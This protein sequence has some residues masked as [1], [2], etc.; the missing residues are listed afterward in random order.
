[1]KLS[2]IVTEDG[3][4]TRQS[5]AK[6]VEPSEMAKISSNIRARILKILKS[7][8]MYPAE[9]AKK[10]NMHEQKIYYHIRELERAGAIQVVEETKKRGTVAKKYAPQ[11]MNYCISLGDVEIARKLGTRIIDQKLDNFLKEFTNEDGT[12]NAEIIVGSPDPH[13]EFK[14]RARD[15]H[16]AIELALF[17][18]QYVR[19]PK[20]FSVKL[21]VDTNLKSE[22][23]MILVGG[24]VTNLLVAEINNYLPVKLSS[25]K[26]WGL[27][28]GK[29]T[30]SDDNAGIIAKVRNPHNSS[31]IL[32][33]AGVRY[34]GTKSA[35][36]ALT[37]KWDRIILNEGKWARIVE[38][39]DLDGDG[40][41]D[42]VDILE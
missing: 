18:G 13:G 41:I 34:T 12:L 10:I 36:M 1:M 33:L 8:P 27:V 4:T 14:A 19:L 39:Y 21:D 6:I 25:E 31:M 26:P 16:Y 28:S 40:R 22:K 7:K 2:Y 3:S 24:P 37:R 15:S 38:G 32:V 9:L 23:N 30:Y 42:E 5:P 11:F 20:E 35:V 29:K 17:L